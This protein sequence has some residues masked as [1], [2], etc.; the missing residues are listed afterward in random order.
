M[1]GLYQPSVAPLKPELNSPERVQ[2][3]NRRTGKV[4]AIM[5]V[6]IQPFIQPSIHLSTHPSF[7]L[8]IHPS[9]HSSIHPSTHPSIHPSIHP[10]IHSSIHPS[11]HPFI[12]SSFLPSLH[13][14]IHLLNRSYSAQSVKRGEET[15]LSLDVRWEINYFHDC[16]PESH[17]S[18][19][20]Y[21][22]F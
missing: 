16:I 8:S 5:N 6:S 1:N 11:I 2:D 18:K 7:H 21:N 22:G 19:R 9:I 17:A 20:R 10:F 3:I 12:R 15:N 13:P 4:E 14:S